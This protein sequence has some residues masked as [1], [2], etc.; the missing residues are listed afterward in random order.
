MFDVIQVGRDVAEV[1]QV[2]NL[3]CKESIWCRNAEVLPALQAPGNEGV[4]RADA[5]AVMFTSN[6]GCRAHPKLT[7]P[8]SLANDI[9]V[10]R[11]LT[12]SSPF[13]SYS[14]QHSLALAVARA[15]PSLHPRSDLVFGGAEPIV[16]AFLGQIA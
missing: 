16:L 14:P 2:S 4:V 8:S 15:G 10:V 6:N 7:P 5:A 13:S 12:A 9:G 1:S 11:S 3:G